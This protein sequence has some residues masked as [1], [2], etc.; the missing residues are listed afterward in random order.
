[1]GKKRSKSAAKSE[2]RLTS[3]MQRL[4]IIAS[5]IHGR[6]C[7][8]GPD[9]GHGLQDSGESAVM[10]WKLKST[11]LCGFGASGTIVAM[12]QIRVRAVGSD[13]GCTING[14]MT[15]TRNCSDA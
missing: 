10:M 6:H 13:C 5:E 15:H 12:H 9:L 1:M 7:V 2:Q 11:R 8:A 3:I 4:D 14:H